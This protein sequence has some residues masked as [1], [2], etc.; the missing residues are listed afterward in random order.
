MTTALARLERHK[1]HQA[2]ERTRSM[3][4]ARYIK[5]LAEKTE[6][7]ARDYETIGRMKEAE[8]A[9]KNAAFYREV[10]AKR[11]RTARQANR[12]WIR[13]RNEIIA[14]KANGARA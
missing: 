11:V 13:L 12:E 5:P 2:L 8:D 14:A 9:R 3:K 6:R 4:R 1:R 10:I 7:N